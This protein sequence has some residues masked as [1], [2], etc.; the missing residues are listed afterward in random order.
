MILGLSTSMFTLL[1]VVVSLLGIATGLV[2][3]AGML[4]SQRRDGWTALFLAA[5][6]LTS[7]SG[8]FFPRE[9]L[10]PSH[11]VGAL[12]LIVLAVATVGLYNYRLAGPWRWI[13]VVT[14]LLAFY[15]NVFVGVVQAF[16]KVAFLSARAPTQADPPFVFTQLIVLVAF[17]A[18]AIVAL[19]SF[20]PRAPAAL[21][22][23]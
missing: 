23:L 10:L 15:F 4:G 11:I 6:V 17:V 16:Q 22:P 13:Y 1:H 19:R 18:T 8:F 5:T 12:T 2:V 14:A 7:V 21:R 9:Q 20:H 3:V